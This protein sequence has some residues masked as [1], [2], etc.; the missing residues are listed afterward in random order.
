MVYDIMWWICRDIGSYGRADVDRFA[1]AK[2]LND[3]S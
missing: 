2:V 3:P 1:V